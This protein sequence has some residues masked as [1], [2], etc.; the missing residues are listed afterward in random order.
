MEADDR[1]AKLDLALSED[2]PAPPRGD[3]TGARARSRAAEVPDAAPMYPAGGRSQESVAVL[4]PERV[5]ALTR[6]RVE[7]IEVQDLD[8]AAG[9]ADG[10]GLDFAVPKDATPPVNGF[11]SITMY[12]IDQ[13]WWFVPNPLN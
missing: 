3:G 13:G 2:R 12:M 9:I 7:R 6:R 8:H 5:I 11:W 1:V 10:A 4:F